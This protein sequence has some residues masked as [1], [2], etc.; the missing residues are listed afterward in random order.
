MEQ[1]LMVILG[2]LGPASVVCVIGI[3]YGI[4]INKKERTQEQ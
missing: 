1:A 3:F 4:Y 2:F